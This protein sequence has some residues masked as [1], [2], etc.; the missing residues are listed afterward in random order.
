M[1]FKRISLLIL[2][3][4]ACCP[5]FAA[6]TAREQVL[7]TL[8]RPLSHQW[9]AVSPDGRRVAYLDEAD[10]KQWLVVNGKPEARFD[11]VLPDTVAFSADG[12]RLAYVARTGEKKVVVVDGLAGKA[13]DD[14]T[15]IAV[16]SLSSDLLGLPDAGSGGDQQMD[17]VERITFSPDGKHVAYAGKSADGWHLVVDG[18]EGTAY[19]ELGVP[20]FSPN[21][22]R[23]ACMA[24]VGGE[25]LLLCDGKE[26]KRYARIIDPLFSPDGAKLAYRAKLGEQRCLVIEEAAGAAA[27][28]ISAVTFSPDGKHLA[29]AAVRD[30]RQMVIVDGQAGTAYD[31]VQA[32]RFSPDGARL[33]YIARVGGEQMVVVDRREGQRYPH[34]DLPPVFSP[35]G[36]HLAY[37]AHTPEGSVL[38]S[39][40]VE[41]QHA[42]GIDAIAYSGDHLICITRNGGKLTVVQD[43]REGP[44]YDALLTRTA[45]TGA[46]TPLLCFSADGTRCAYAARANREW[47]VQVGEERQGPYDAVRQL[48]FSPNGKQLVY[49]A[50]LHGEQGTRE[51]LVVNGAPGKPAVK[52]DDASLR[53]TPDGA[54]LLCVCRTADGEHVLV[55]G[56]AGTTYQSILG[57]HTPC[58][59]LDSANQFHYLAF[60]A[61]PA[62]PSQHPATDTLFPD[63]NSETGGKLVLV[64]ETIGP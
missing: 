28:A 12:R 42:L 31:E 64:Q 35:D 5:A 7:A 32:V 3:I 2:C 43:G 20:F 1:P 53:F 21:S 11:A 41:G 38:V 44:A 16:P 33:A 50:G 4:A 56:A 47:F 23:L 40:G 54:H 37:A 36:R 24:T 15:K 62:P 27:D 39:D 10:G 52:I 9:F 55:D 57:D 29:Y 45:D 49:I 46:A 18:K 25:Q 13:Y 63:A 6:R 60:K 8:R 34:I 58:I 14:L 26:G 51:M 61:D 59:V 19:A 22:A 30:G 17:Y 48:C